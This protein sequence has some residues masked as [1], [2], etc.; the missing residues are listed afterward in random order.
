MFSNIFYCLSISFVLTLFWKFSSH[1]KAFVQD[2]KNKIVKYQ[3]VLDL[4]VK[5]NPKSGYVV[6]AN[7]FDEEAEYSICW[8]CST[9]DRADRRFRIF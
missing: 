7:E 8:F 1:K 3:T 5:L 6:S 4:P 2:P 9:S